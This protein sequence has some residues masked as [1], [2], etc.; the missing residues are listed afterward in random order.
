MKP[1]ILLTLEGGCIQSVHAF[2]TLAE[3]IVLDHDDSLEH[4]GPVEA[5]ELDTELQRELHALHPE[6]VPDPDAAPNDGVLSDEAW[7]ETFLVLRPGT[8][9][10]VTGCSPEEQAY[11]PGFSG[12]VL[13]HA[14]DGCTL[15]AFDSPRISL[16]TKTK[17]ADAWWVAT[18]DLE[19][20]P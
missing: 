3:L 2:N 18:C 4:S 8:R 14:N 6:N 12:V 13:T 17:P 1:T 10:I 9:V 20:L 19:A 11:A 16:A 5:S 15:V 7:L